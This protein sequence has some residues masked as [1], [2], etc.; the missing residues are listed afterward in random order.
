MS[1]KKKHKKKWKRKKDRK[2]EQ[3]EEEKHEDLRK[4]LERK[5][6][7]VGETSYDDNSKADPLPSSSSAAFSTVDKDF[8]KL[9]SSSSRP[10]SPKRKRRQRS[11]SPDSRRAAKR[12]RRSRSR[13]RRRRRPPRDKSA[14]P[15]EFRRGSDVDDNSSVSLSLSPSP[16]RR[17]LPSSSLR[18]RSR[19]PLRPGSSSGRPAPSYPGGSTTSRH[20][21]KWRYYRD[22]DRRWPPR[23]WSDDG[24]RDYPD[25]RRR[26]RWR[27]ESWEDRVR[28]FVDQNNRSSSARNSASPTNSIARESTS[29]SLSPASPPLVDTSVPPPSMRPSSAAA[30][31]TKLSSPPGGRMEDEHDDPPLLPPGVDAEAA[32]DLEED[33]KAT[34]VVRYIGKRLGRG[35]NGC[36][37]RLEGVFSYNLLSLLTRAEWVAAK[38]LRLLEAAGYAEDTLLYRVEDKGAPALE[39]E[40]KTAVFTGKV[41]LDNKPELVAQVLRVIECLVK[42]HTPSTRKEEV[43]SEEEEEEQKAEEVEEEQGRKGGN[44][45]RI[46]VGHLLKQLTAKQEVKEEEK[47]E[48]PPARPQ[49]PWTFMWDH[50]QSESLRS[51]SDMKVFV[52]KDLLRLGDSAL[53]PPGRSP[54]DVAQDM[55]SC[56]VLAGYSH[57]SLQHM[58]MQSA[59]EDILPPK[60]QITVGLDGAEKAKKKFLFHVV[61]QRLEKMRGQMPE[62]SREQMEYLVRKCLTYVM[63]GCDK[64]PPSVKNPTGSNI[65]F[66][67]LPPGL[68]EMEKEASIGRNGETGA[69]TANN[70]DE[71]DSYVLEEGQTPRSASAPSAEDRESTDPL[72]SILNPSGAPVK[73]NELPARR[74]MA[75]SVHAEWLTLRGRAHLYEISVYF[76]DLS[77]QTYYMMPEALQRQPP[78]V[79]EALGFISNPDRPEFYF[80]QVGVG[81]VKT[82]SLEK[83]VQKL[84]K[85]FE[86]KRHSSTS[87]NRNNGLV[88]NFYGEEELAVV[89]EA[90]EKTGHKNVF[91]DTVKGLGYVES[92]MER[93]KSKNVEYSGP[94]VSIGGSDSFY[95]TSVRRGLQ[96]SELVSKTKAEALH[97]A[98]EF[99][100]EGAAPTYRSYFR[101]YCFPSLGPGADR[102]RR[103]HRARADLYHLEAFLSD[104][105]RAQ[106]AAVS[107]EGVFAPSGLGGRRELRD[108]HTV[109]ASGACR[110]LVDAGYTLASLRRAHERDPEFAVNSAVFLDRMNVSQRLKLM[111]QTMR[112]V[113]IVQSYFQPRGKR[114]G[115]EDREEG[116]NDE[117]D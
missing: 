93:N 5:R 71:E 57:A 28:A 88:L 66:N 114:Q 76:S 17:P 36:K 100:L 80:V 60:D 103:R 55:I 101:E 61:L 107:A 3:Q 67:Y 78:E 73:P 40:L 51:F 31:D 105:L 56:L 24:R 16:E 90:F 94:K 82:I 63:R 110:A 19:S 13:E 99:F 59:A 69:M 50:L 34:P 14:S 95:L 84:V 64:V 45:A 53:C 23:R 116:E 7:K 115:K 85:F 35:K 79:L 48:T 83:A 38:T 4:T 18:S 42:Y 47:E 1:K 20:P 15:Q 97:Q 91:L 72:N 109:V 10:P 37:L 9:N 54:F 33:L 75:G 12:K 49:N 41:K 98:L 27:E 44:A 43:S 11:R 39:M 74:Y 2:E 92:Y 108:K 86:E 29:A 6:K 21:G 68:R 65:V 62:M 87:E 96:T 25:D 30:A 89:V 117:V 81:V 102:V 113:R 22:D 112:C 46:G 70:D 106:R 26:H 58:V 104:R 77:S 8:R 32:G 52:A 111:D